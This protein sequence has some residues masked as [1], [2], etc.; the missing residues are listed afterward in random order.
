MRESV[1]A[2]L[3]AALARFDGL[4]APPAAAQTTTAADGTAR[5]VTAANA[6]LATL[7]PAQRSSVLLELRQDL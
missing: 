4:S 7:S 2:L 3:V 1:W 5:A 6:F